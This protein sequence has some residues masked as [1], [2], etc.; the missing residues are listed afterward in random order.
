MVV[1]SAPMRP[2]VSQTSA[3]PFAAPG[4]KTPR[5]NNAY[6]SQKA[7]SDGP[8]DMISSSSLKSFR[9]GTLSEIWK[10]EKSPTVGALL[11][12][13]LS[14]WARRRDLCGALFRARPAQNLRPL[15]MKLRRTAGLQVFLGAKVVFETGLDVGASEK[16]RVD[17]DV[18]ATGFVRLVERESVSGCEA[19]FD[20]LPEG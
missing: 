3:V 5:A 14:A 7:K 9:D 2:T 8:I 11:C 1:I 19:R 12:C 15:P 10:K 4:M 20:Y 16:F 17:K 18:R 6:I 13:F